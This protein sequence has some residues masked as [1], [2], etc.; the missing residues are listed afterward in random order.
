MD[1]QK[2]IECVRAFNRFFVVELKFMEHNYLGTGFS[3]AQMR[4]LYEIYS[5]KGITAGEICGTLKLDK[6]YISRM[7]KGFEKDGLVTRKMSSEDNRAFCLFLTDAGE[8]QLQNLI[9]IAGDDIAATMEKLSGED[10]EEVCAAMQLIMDK[11]SK[12]K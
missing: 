10:A 3:V 5:R 9:K 8:K 11:F 6:G 1:K 7:I 4:T 12:T 2:M